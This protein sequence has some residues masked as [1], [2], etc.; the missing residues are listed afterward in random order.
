MK[1]A[2]LL[3]VGALS[4]WAAVMSAA[5]VDAE[6][7]T[8]TRLRDLRDRI[9]ST[10]TQGTGLQQRYFEAFPS[11]FTA[12][13]NV[14]V[15]QT[16]RDI[17]LRPGESWEFGQPYV[18]L[19][20]RTYEHVDHSQYMRK[21]LRIGIEAGDWGG[22][23]KDRIRFLYPGDIYQRLVFRTACEQRTEE[24]ARE[25]MSTIYAL[26]PEF[27]DEEFVA[28][29][30]SLSW[31]ESDQKYPLDWFLEEI[32]ARYPQRC[33]LTQKLRREFAD[34]ADPRTSH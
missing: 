31:A 7:D 15:A 12:L 27:T 13:S 18:V 2:Q 9:E 4:C 33:A 3:L 22:R 8:A 23:E 28:I 32:C 30:H 10:V 29:Y 11:S 16:H 17:L 34:T 21:L 1:P 20:C 14:M 24:A 26:L 6:R 25:Q 5:P 19:M